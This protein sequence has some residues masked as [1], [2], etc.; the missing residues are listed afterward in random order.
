[1]HAI[2]HG[3]YNIIL[4]GIQNKINTNSHG[5][6][7]ETT[8]ENNVLRRKGTPFHKVLYLEDQQKYYSRWYMKKKGTPYRIV[9]KRTKKITIHIVLVSKKKNATPFFRMA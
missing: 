9:H 8:K 7:V 6:Y 3:R 5:I 2:S 4:L 1:M